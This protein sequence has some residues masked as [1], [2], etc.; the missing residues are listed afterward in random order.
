MVHPEV[1]NY[2]MLHDTMTEHSL[3]YTLDQTKKS[4]DVENTSTVNMWF[5]CIDAVVRN[6]DIYQI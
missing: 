2:F 1:T 3:E 6:I 4:L 5:L